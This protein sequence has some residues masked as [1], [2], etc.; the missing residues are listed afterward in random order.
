[1][2]RTFC[3]NMP[4]R[5]VIRW[6]FDRMSQYS[7]KFKFAVAFTVLCGSQALAAPAIT[8]VVNAARN[9]YLNSPIAAGAIFVIYGSGLGPVNLSIASSPFQSTS[10][11][12]TSV[13]VTVG[14]TTV[15]ALMYYTSATQVAAL[16]PSNAPFGSGSFTVTYNGSTSEPVFQGVGPSNFAIFTVDSTGGGPAIVTYPITA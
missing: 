10:L 9:I 6:Y 1:M 7:N 5:S 4:T 2:N 14:S 3:R 12:G 11:N 16:L 15:N 13:A 8:S